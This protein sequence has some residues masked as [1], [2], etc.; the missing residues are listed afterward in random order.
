MGL[1]CRCPNADGQ[2][3]PKDQAGSSRSWAA[4]LPLQHGCVACVGGYTAVAEMDGRTPAIGVPG[5]QTILVLTCLH[6][7]A[8]SFGADE[9][10]LVWRIPLQG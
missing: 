6:P 1:Q 2:Q 7:M 4:P 8:V 3:R 9:I 10:L 5:R